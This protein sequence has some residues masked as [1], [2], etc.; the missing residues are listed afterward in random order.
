MCLFR[1]KNA[2]N[3]FPSS[4]NSGRD[5]FEALHCLILWFLA[6]SCLLPCLCRHI[7][8][9]L[10]ILPKPSVDWRNSMKPLA[11]LCIASPTCVGEQMFLH[12]EFL[13][14]L[15]TRYLQRII[16]VIFD[17]FNPYKPHSKNVVLLH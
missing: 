7:V 14:C 1:H 5:D 3:A 16:N 6:S 2:L 4:S 17:L 13:Q 8:A 12:S 15:S 9:F 11:V 10:G